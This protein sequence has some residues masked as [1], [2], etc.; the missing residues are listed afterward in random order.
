MLEKGKNIAGVEI[1]PLQRKEKKL[2]EKKVV[3]KSKILNTIYS[4]SWI[5]VII[6][7]LRSHKQSA[8]QIVPQIS[9]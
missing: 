4:N 9:G 1:V 2:I 6:Y 8:E 7:P 3:E 5:Y